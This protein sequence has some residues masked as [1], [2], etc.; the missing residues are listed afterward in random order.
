MKTVN[1]I[2]MKTDEGFEGPYPIGTSDKYVNCT[3]NNEKVTLNAAL[4]NI[5]K[6]INEVKIQWTDIGV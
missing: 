2:A 4:G 3:N 6:Q 5:Q 1:E